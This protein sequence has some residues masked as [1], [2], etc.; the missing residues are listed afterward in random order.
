M[1]S[2]FHNC[3]VFLHTDDISFRVDPNHHHLTAHPR[4]VPAAMLQF[5]S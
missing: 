3:F 1:A 5:A 2:A 4:L